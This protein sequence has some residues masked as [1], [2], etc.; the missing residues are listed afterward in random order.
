VSIS[1]STKETIIPDSSRGL[2]NLSPKTWFTA[3]TITRLRVSGRGAIPVNSRHIASRFKGMSE[4]RL[5]E[6]MQAFS[7]KKC[8][9]N[10]GLDAVMKKQIVK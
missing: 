6:V 1:Y 10:H 8:I 3:V 4:E 7:F 9:V 2:R 5:D